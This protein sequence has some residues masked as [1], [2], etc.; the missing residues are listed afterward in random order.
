[1]TQGGS[2]HACGHGL[3]GSGAATVRRSVKQYIERIHWRHSALLR[4]P[5]EEGGDGKVYMVARPIVQG[6]GRGSCTPAF[7]YRNEVTNGGTL[8]ITGA[9]FT[10][11]GEAR[12]SDG[13]GSRP[14]G[15]GRVTL[16]GTGIE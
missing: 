1:M 12:M 4:T 14:V 11:H 9:K 2:G 15:V 13:A 7:G 5:A 3:L 16:T 6:C 8:A 10:F